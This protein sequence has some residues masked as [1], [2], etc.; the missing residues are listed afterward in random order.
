[1]IQCLK[2]RIQNTIQFRL[3]ELPPISKSN[4]YRIR[5][6]KLQQ[7]RERFLSA[8]PMCEHCQEHGRITPATEVDHRLALMNGGLDV[9]S[10][11]QALCDECHKAKTIVDHRIRKQ[12]AV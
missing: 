10:N 6:R 9:D 5:G 3:S 7:I 12:G 11:R 4:D 8:H 1:M 2:P